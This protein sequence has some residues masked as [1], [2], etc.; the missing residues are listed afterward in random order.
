M[1]LARLSNFLIIP[2]VREKIRVKLAPAIP[3]GPPTT[4]TEEIT[5]TPPLVALKTIKILSMYSKAATYLL[6]FLLHNFLRLTS[7][8][9]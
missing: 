9:K 8:L 1:F 3:M 7:W 5:Q 6:H 2:V 4:L